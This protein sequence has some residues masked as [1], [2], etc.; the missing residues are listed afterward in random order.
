MRCPRRMLFWLRSFLPNDRSCYEDTTGDPQR[1]RTAVLENDDHQFD[2]TNSI[3]KP[4]QILSTLGLLNIAVTGFAHTTYPPRACP[5]PMHVSMPPERGVARDGIPGMLP[6]L[7]HSTETHL[8]R[9]EGNQLA[10]GQCK[11]YRAS[12]QHPPT[13]GITGRAITQSRRCS[14]HQGTCHSAG[15]GGV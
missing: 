10:V 2:P 12:E 11:K 13:L 9:T 6:I 5:Q 3:P 7:L 1:N 4:V 15:G 8:F 14:A